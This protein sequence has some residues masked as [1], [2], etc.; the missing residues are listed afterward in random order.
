MRAQKIIL[1]VLIVL[2]LAQYNLWQ[3][4]QHMFFYKAESVQYILLGLL[5]Y[6]FLNII[7]KLS[8]SKKLIK[9]VYYCKML[10]FIWIIFGV[11]DLCDLFF[12][13][14]TVFGWNEWLFTGSAIIYTL[15][16]LR[17]QWKV[18]HKTFS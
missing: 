18:N 1:V 16:K 13:N 5:L 11:N 7:E 6:S 3:L 10:T 2:N 12:F 9:D 8:Q 14:P 4:I 17:N 15:K